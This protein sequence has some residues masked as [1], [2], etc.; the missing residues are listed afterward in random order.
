M[1]SPVPHLTKLDESFDDIA[2]TFGYAITLCTLATTIGSY[3]PVHIVAYVAVSTIVFVVVVACIRR[4]DTRG[5]EEHSRSNCRTAKTIFPEVVEPAPR[6]RYYSV[7]RYNSTKSCFVHC[8]KYGSKRKR[9]G[10]AVE[11][12]RSDSDEVKCER[13]RG[14]EKILKRLTRKTVGKKNKLIAIFRKKLGQ[15]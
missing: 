7:S 14:F 3:L 5:R 2:T 10:N 6:R 4:N 8:C 13:S 1:V 12:H 15:S 9:H 11:E